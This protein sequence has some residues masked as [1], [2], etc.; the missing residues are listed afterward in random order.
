MDGLHDLDLLEESVLEVLVG[1][2][3]IK[4]DVLA[5]FWMTLMATFLWVLSDSP[6]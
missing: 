2:D 5:F 4:K 3:W 6:T 1:V